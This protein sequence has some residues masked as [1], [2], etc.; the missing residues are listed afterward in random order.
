MNRVC[1][2]LCSCYYCIF[3]CTLLGAQRSQGRAQIVQ[4]V[5]D[6]RAY[7]LRHVEELACLSFDLNLPSVTGEFLRFT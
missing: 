1:H 7:A 4:L 6:G 3:Y 5:R 2:L